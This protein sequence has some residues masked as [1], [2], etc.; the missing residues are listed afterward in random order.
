MLREGRN[1]SG[2]FLSLVSVTTILYTVAR[3]ADFLYK[4]ENSE[5]LDTDS[6]VK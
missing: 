2:I 5:V 6:A 1:V 4:I 3:R